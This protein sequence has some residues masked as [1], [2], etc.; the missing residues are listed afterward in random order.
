MKYILLD[1]NYEAISFFL[2]LFFFFLRNKHTHT[3]GRGKEV[4]TQMPFLFGNPRQFSGVEPMKI[5]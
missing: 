1:Q 4:L 3:Q 5:K 2:F